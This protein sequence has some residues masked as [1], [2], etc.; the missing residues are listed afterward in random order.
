MYALIP[1]IEL[2]LSFI[3]IDITNADEVYSLS[4]Q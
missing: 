2:G 3:C 1:F 4:N